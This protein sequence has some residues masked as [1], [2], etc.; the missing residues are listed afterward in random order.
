MNSEFR[1]F[2]DLGPKANLSVQRRQLVTELRRIRR[3]AVVHS[4][5]RQRRQPPIER[6]APSPQAVRQRGRH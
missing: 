3:D 1:S 5:Q 4:Y 6:I 2:M